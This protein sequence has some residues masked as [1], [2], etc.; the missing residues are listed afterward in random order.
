LRLYR[1]IAAMD[2][3]APLPSL[4]SQKPKWSEGA[5]LAREW[6]LNRFAD[7]LAQLSD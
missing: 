2:A 6:Q 5:K 4:R 7:R 1:K 3:S